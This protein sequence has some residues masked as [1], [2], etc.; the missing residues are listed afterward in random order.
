M[1][2]Y[3]LGLSGSWW[4]LILLIVLATGFTLFVYRRTVPEIPTSKKAILVTLRWI[5]IF[6]LLF[7]LFEPMFT[8]IRG[9]FEKP[10]LAV[11]LDNSLS[12]ALVDAKG[13]RKQDYKNA[14]AG[15]DFLSLP[16]SQRNIISFDYDTKEYKNFNFDSLK[17]KGQLTDISK[18]FKFVNQVL[19]KENT[20]AV[21]LITDGSYNTGNNPIYESDL[22][23]KKVYVIGIGDTTEP[24]DA[25][26]Q[27]IIT[28]D[29]AYIDNPVPVNVNLKISGFSGGEVSIKLLDNGAQISEQKVTIS[30]DKQVYSL[31][32]Q[33]N[34]KAEGIRKLTASVSNLDGEL[35]LKNNSLSEFINVLKNKRKIV[36][37]S[38]SPNPDLTFLRSIYEGEKGVEVKTFIQKQGAEYFEGN[39]TKALLHDAEMIVLIGFPINTT[40]QNSM[41]L[42]RDEV[43]KGKPLF[44]IAS[45]YLDYIKLK[46]LEDYLPFNTIS[47]KPQEFLALGDFKKESASNPILK[48]SGA[49]SDIESWNQLPPIF[50]TETFVRVKPESEVLAGIKVNNTQLKEP[51]ILTRNF[52]NKKSIAVLGYGLYRWKLLGY[53]AEVSKG[54]TNVPDL[55]STFVQNSHRWLSINQEY[56]NVIIKT[57]KKVYNQSEKVEFYAQIYDAMYAP[58]EN[59]NVQIK[60]TGGN[61]NRELMLNS[62]G[63]GRYTGFVE[64]LA[65]GDYFFSGDATQNGT[66]LG[67]DNGR[68]SIGDVSLE[69]LDLRMNIG[70]LRTLA[71]RSGGKFYFASNASSF[72]NDL[73]K[74]AFFKEKAMTLRSEYNLW[75][76]SWILG[77]AILC[78]TLEWFLRKR[79]G[80]I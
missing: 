59:A 48:I 9:A 1:N 64:G 38:G 11:L 15:S 17:L 36:I 72:M 32:F 26:I 41:E 67:K 5:A 18:S 66:L 30:S 74:D 71:E 33:Y 42:I 70:L 65:E 6:L 31:L 7:I 25:S 73:R 10:K 75:N 76:L 21:L 80:L 49:E 45:Q 8:L 19:E 3:H 68:F 35:T 14:V 2:S 22:T 61:Q 46:P 54:R 56:K 77:L 63:N 13:D 4:W 43:E 50:R 29:I 51:L 57:T 44:F 55:Y 20:G 60:I 27:S 79:S 40:P 78:L 28:N 62:I 53:A 47:S 24:K 37:F 23:G 52:Q 58:V 16:E 34:P 69:Y 12:M 39:P